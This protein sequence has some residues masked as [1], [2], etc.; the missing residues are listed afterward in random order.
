MLFVGGGLW[1]GERVGVIGVTHESQCL[2]TSTLI[3]LWTATFWVPQSHKAAGTQT[4]RSLDAEFNCLAEECLAVDN[5]LKLV[6]KA[7]Q[8]WQHRRK[9]IGI[10]LVLFMLMAGNILYG[11]KSWQ[12]LKLISKQACS[13]ITLIRL[14]SLSSP[15]FRVRSL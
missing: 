2:P 6:L 9:D 14:H 15:T 3:L 10:L 7:S 1:M 11:L 13:H 8:M 12:T 5:C 4:C